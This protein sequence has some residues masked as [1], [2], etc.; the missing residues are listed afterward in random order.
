M[1]STH[2]CMKFS[3]AK[4]G[5]NAGVSI[6]RHAHPYAGPA[7]EYPASGVSTRNTLA[8]ISGIYRVVARFRGRASYIDYR[9]A[10]F[11]EV[12]LKRV[13]SGKTPRDRSR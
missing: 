8:H 10:S 4:G 13:S 7:N 2:S 5:A 11:F 9:D 1:K 6:C 12:I 3:C